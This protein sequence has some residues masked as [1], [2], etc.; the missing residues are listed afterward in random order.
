MKTHVFP[1]GEYWYDRSCWSWVVRSVDEEGNQIGE[2]DYVGT[3]KGRDEAI[4]RRTMKTEK[5]PANKGQRCA[6]QIRV[7]G[8]SMPRWRQCR[9]HA[10]RHNASG[11]C[12]QHAN[13]DA[14]ATHNTIYLR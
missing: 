11:F 4:A 14:K 1:G 7:K 8:L 13:A 5:P 2:A 6:K 9:C 10:M 3:K 12:R